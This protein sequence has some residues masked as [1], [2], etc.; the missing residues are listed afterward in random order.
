MYY[1][2]D[3]LIRQDIT[4]GQ[5]G[6][7][8]TLNIYLLDSACNPL[9]NAFTSVWQANATGYYSGFT[10][11]LINTDVFQTVF[12]RPFPLPRLE[13][14]FSVQSCTAIQAK[15]LYS[16]Q[17]ELQPTATMQAKQTS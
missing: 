12:L 13:S 1:V 9:T 16:L 10:G 7:P 11:G 5:R 15:Y 4:E 14:S 3:V 17:G 2:N 6:I 8:V